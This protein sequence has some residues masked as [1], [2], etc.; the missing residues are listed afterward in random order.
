MNL[1]SKYTRL[2]STSTLLFLLL[3]SI[4]SVTISGRPRFGDE[5]DRYLQAQ[6]I[7]ERQTLAIQQIPGYDQ[8]IGADGK[9]Y[10]SQF[11]MGYGL[12][13]VPAYWLGRVVSNIY[14]YADQDWIP[15]LFVGLVNPVIM[16]FAG[17]IFFKFS[18][19]IGV[20]PRIAIWTTVLFGLGTM[21]WPYTKSIYRE[22]TQTLTLLLAAYAVSLYHRKY[23]RKFLFISG[24]ALGYLAFTKI[25]NLVSL[26]IFLGYIW[27]NDSAKAEQEPPRSIWRRAYP[28]IQFLIPVCLILGIQGIINIVKYGNF[29]DLG[30]YNYSHPIG[31]FSLTYFLPGATGLLFSSSKGLFLYA[32]PVLLFFFG[33]WALFRRDKLDGLLLLTLILANLAYNAAYVAWEGGA[34]WGPRY[35]LLIVPLM[36]LPFGL[37]LE[38]T[39]GWWKKLAL[40]LSG[41]T[42]LIGLAIQFVAGLVDE[43]EYLD[44]TGNGIQLVGGI[45]YL[46]HKAVDSMFIYLEP[47]IAGIQLNLYAWLVL[48]LVLLTGGWLVAKMLLDQQSDSSLRNDVILLIGG[49]TMLMATLITQLISVYPQ[50]LI[51]KGNTQYVAAES[52]FAGGRYCEAQYFYLNSLLWGTK[53]QQQVLT[54]LGDI[55]PA[56]PGNSLEI[57]ELAPSDGAAGAL[58]FSEDPE[59]TIVGEYSMKVRALSH[60]EVAGAAATEFVDV[61][62]ATEYEFSG[63]I[64]AEGIHGS[65]SGLASWYEDNGAWQNGRNIDVV[66]V[67]G[68]HGWQPFRQIITTLPKTHRALLRAGIWQANGTIWVDGLRVVEIDKSTHSQS[69]CVK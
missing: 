39:H 5:V 45:D 10:Y 35:I 51:A 62:P 14:P 46:R 19:L 33:W 44:A 7:V 54:R 16:A 4:Y 59:S 23:A 15:V 56:T 64:K 52:F 20:R 42:F 58:E 25:A 34:F 9:T 12:L 43:R 28:I 47:R 21:A 38:S 30:P 22:P 60:R 65:G 37:C 36:I 29:L 18:R 48:S 57:G 1:L 31:Y 63:W 69:L 26:P 32:P 50:I 55:S 68:S 24:I 3:L 61:R 49:I 27:F 6:S 40:G 8:A 67:T 13:L 41:L 17:V 2:F 11:E 53:F 66:S